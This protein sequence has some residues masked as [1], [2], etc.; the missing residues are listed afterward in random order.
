MKKFAV[1]VI[2]VAALFYFKP[3]LFSFGKKGAFDS[4]GHAQVLLFTQDGCGAPCASAVQE[5]TARG[6]AFQE[7]KL[8]NDDNIQRYHDLGGAATIP[9]L[10]VGRETVQG[11]GKGDFAS[12]LA[13]NF[14]DSVLTRAELLFYKNHFD[15]TGK[16]VVYM[17]GASWC[18][19]CKQLRAE[20]ESR[21]I[22]FVEIDV[23]HDADKALIEDAMDLSGY[24]TTYVGYKRIVGANKTDQVMAALKTA[25][26][27]SG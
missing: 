6:V 25:V 21:K 8:D 24:P 2:A 20:M 15:D 11:Y 12:A 14:G 23:D 3:G 16:P 7:I 13:E 1:L 17:Y 9:L 10:A 26:K 4:K 27:H 18:G 19:Y 22:A 5:L